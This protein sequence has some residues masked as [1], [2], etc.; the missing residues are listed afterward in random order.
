MENIEIKNL[1][2]NYEK[3]LEYQKK[4]YNEKKDDEEFKIKNRQ[5][6]NAWY[7]LNKERKKEYYLK[8]KI[9]LKK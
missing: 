9:Y 2:T 7:H 4:K 3:K 8:K 6:A 5:R 1:M